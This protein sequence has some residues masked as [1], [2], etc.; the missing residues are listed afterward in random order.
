M[1]AIFSG[2]GL[3][4]QRGS[5]SVLGSAGVLGDPAFGRAADKIMVNAATGNLLVDRKD[6]FLVGRGPDA[7]YSQTYNSQG[8]PN[9]SWAQSIYHTL[10]NL[11]GT[12]NTAG[13]TITRGDGDG[14]GAVYTYDAAKGAYVTTEG[15]GSHDEIRNTGGTWTWTDGNS[16]TTETYLSLSGV[17]GYYFLSSVSDADGNAQT[18]SWN[19]N[20]TLNRITNADGDYVQFTLSNGLPTQITTYTAAGAATLTRTRYV[21][22]SLRRLTSVT[23]DLTPGDHSIGDGKSYTNSYTYDGTSTRITSISQTD[24]SKLDI[25]YVLVGSDYRVA[26]LTQTVAAGSTRTTSFSYDTVNRI[27]SI[28]DANGQVTSLYYDALKQLTKIISPPPFAGAAASVVQFGYN[29]SGDLVSVTDSNNAAT[30]YAYDAAG[31]LISETDPLGN[32]TT[33]TYGAKNELLIETR[34][35]S[36]SASAD[37]AQTTRYAYDAENHLRYVVGPEGSVVEYRYDRY[38]QRIAEIE[39]PKALY[40]LIG[41]PSTTAISEATLDNWVSGLSDKSSVKRTNTYYDA[42]GNVTSVVTYSS[43]TKYGEGSD[44]PQIISPGTNTTVSATSDGYHRI[45]KTSGSAGDWDADAHSTTKVEGDFVLRLRP[46]QNNKYIVAGL[47]T[48]PAANASYT[49]P[50]YGLYFVADGSVYYMESGSYVYLNTTYA[51]GDV[52]WIQRVGTTISYYKGATLGAAQAAGALRTRTSATEALYFD[53]SF[54]QTGAVLDVTFNPGEI[55]TGV[56]TAVKLE[57]DGLY[58]IVKTGGAALGWDADAR[59]NIKADGDF[60]LRLRPAQ[61]NAHM[62]GGVAY[63]P[64]ANAD[65][66]NPN[67]G[68]YFNADS[69][70]YYMESGSYV[71]LGVTHSAG[72]NFWLVRSGTTVSYY[73]G[74]SLEAAMAAGPLRTRTGVSGTLYF[75]SSLYSTGARM[76]A[77][78]TPAT[79]IANGVN[80]SVTQSPDGLYRVSKTLGTDNWDADAR[81]STKTDGDFVLRLRPTQT[82]RHF[83]GGVASAPGANASYTNPDYGFFFVPGGVVYYMEAGNYAP[84]GASFAAG[85]NFWLTRVGS[86]I[87]YYKGPTLEAAI[88]AGAIRTRTGVSGTFHF[89]SSLHGAGTVFDVSFTPTEGNAVAATVN[90]VNFAYDQSGQLLSRSKEGQNAETYIYDG[91]GRRIGSTDLNGGSTSIVFNDAATQTVVTLASGLVQTSTYNKAGELVSQTDSGS[92][93]AGGTTAHKYDR[94]G[95][96][97]QTTDASGFNKYFVYDKA[98]RL[99]ADVLHNGALTEYRY[100][101]TNRLVATVRYHNMVSAGTLTTLSDPNSTVEISAIRPAFNAADVCSWSVYDAGGRLVSTIDGG[102]GVQAYA[103]D[104]SDRL[105]RTIRY[106]NLLSAPLI[107]SFKTTPPTATVLPIADSSRDSVT[108]N[109]YDKEGHLIAVLDG[110]GYL[111]RIL[112]DRAGQKI[113]QI[114]YLNPTN[115]AYRASGTLND[116]IATQPTHADDRRT[117]YAYDGQGQL[118]FEVDG[119]NQVVEYGYDGAGRVTSTTRYSGALPATSQYGYDTIKSLIA[120]SGLAASAANR[121]SWVVYDAAGRVA[122]TINADDGVTRYTYNIRGKVT[123]TVEY[124][125]RRST[126][127]LPTLATMASWAAGQDSNGANRVTRHFYTARDELRFSVDAEGFVSRTDYDAAG[128]VTREVRWDNAIAIGDSATIDTVNGL[129]TGTWADTRYGYDF[130]G[131]IT[132]VWNGENNWTHYAYHG[133]RKLASKS[134]VESVQSWTSYTYDGAGRVL[135]ELEA[136]GTA[137]VARTAYAYDGH[138]N[139]TSVTDPNNNVTTRT[140]DRIGQMLSQTDP[141]AKTASYQ[142]NAFGEVVKSTDARGYS[143]YN[144]YDRLGRATVTR[145][146]EDYVSETSYDVF[147]NALSVT[148]RY[149]RANNGASV[150]VLPTYVAHAQDST[151]SFQYDRLGRLLKLTD[152]EGH[153][154][155]YTLDAFGNRISVRNKLGGIVTNSFDRRGRLLSETL[156]ATSVDSNGTTT[157]WSVTNRFQYDARGN[158]TKKFEAYGLAEQRST[159]YV[160]DKA[161]RLIEKRGDTVSVLSQSSHA[162]LSPV[163]PTEQFKYDQRGRVIETVDSL[164]A[165][166]LFYYDK[167]NRKTA[168][169][170]TGGTA[171]TGSLSTFTYDKNGNVLTNRIYGTAVAVPATAGGAAPGAPGGE[172]RE[173]SFTYDKL[174][175]LLTTSVANARTGAWNGTYFATGVGT[176]T[177]TNEYDSSGNV[178]KTTDGAGG[179]TL[180]YY[181]RAGRRIATVDRENY[182]TFLTLDAEGNVTQEERLAVQVSGPTTASN[183]ATLRA[184]VAGNSADRITQFAY[185]RNGRRISETRL[186]VASSTVDGSTGALGSG[187]AHSAIQY[188]YNGLGLVSQKT[189]A[190]GDYVTYTYDSTG[191]LLQESRAPF[192]DHNGATVRPTTFYS[193]DGL[194]N[195]TMSRLGGLTPGAGDRITRY[196]YGPGGRL[197]WTRDATGAQF[198]YYYDAAGNIVRENWTRARA[199][200][201]TTLDGIL[202]NRDLK[203]RVTSQALASWNGSAWVRGD[204]QDSAYNTYGDVAQRGTNGLWQEQFAYDGAGRLYRSNSG[205][206]VWRYFVYDGAGNQTLA[207]E[208]EG[209]NL[210]NLTI[211]QALAVATANGAYYVGGAYIDGINATINVFNKRGQSVQTRQ[212]KRQLNATA[213]AVDLAVSRTYNAFGEVATETDARGFT[214]DFV[215]NT[216]GRLAQKLNPTVS[217][218]TESGAVGSARPT[219]YYYFDAAGRTV[220]Y[221][222]ANGNLMTRS[223]LAGTGHEGSEALVTMEYHADGGRIRSDYDLFGDKRISWDEVNRR[224]DM[225][226]DAMGRMTQLSH[227]NGLIDYFGYDILGQKIA[228]WNN[229]NQTPVYGPPQ[230][231]WVQDG[232]WDP[233][234]GWVDTSHWETQTPIVGYTPEKEVTDYDLQGRITRQVAFGGDT[235]TVGYVWSGSLATAGMGTFGGWTETTTYANGRTA[236]RKTDVFGREVSRTDLGGHTT[237]MTY[238]LAGRLIQRSG[239]D[240]LAFEYLNTGQASRIHTSYYTDAQNWSSKGTTYG[241]DA[242]GNLVS[243]RLVD[244]GHSYS[245]WWDPYYGWQ[246]SDYGWSNVYKNATATYDGMNRLVSWTEAGSGLMPAASIGYQYDLASNIRRS[247]AQYRSLDAN[248]TPSPYVSTQDN[249]YRYDSMNRVV[250]KGMLSGGQI[251]RGNGGVDYLY[252]QA[253]ERIRAT[254]TTTA[255]ATIYDPYAYWDPYYGYGNQ[256]ITVPYDADSREDYTFDAAGAL[257]TVR[258]AQSGYYDNGDGTLTVTPPPATGALRASYTHDLMGRMTHQVDWLGDGTYAAFDRT[259]TYNTKGQVTNETVVQKQGGDTI[260]SYSYND[261][262]SGAAYALGAVTYSSTTTYKNNAYQSVSTTTNSYAWYDGAVQSAISYKPNSSQSTTFSTSFYYDAA[263]QLSSI[264]IYDG[265][266]RSITFVN[267]GA[268]QAIKRDES[269]NKWN[270]GDPHEIWYRFGGKQLGYTGNNG[271]IDTDYATSISNRTLTPGTGAYRFGQSYGSAYADFDLSGE[272]ITSYGQ[273]SV[274]GSYTAR[275]GDT[276]Q[277]IA[278]QLWGDSSLWYKL[279]EANGL[280]GAGALAEGQRIT[281]PAGVLKSQHNASTLRPYDPAET[282]GDVSPTTPQPQAPK[283]AKKNK[284]GIF[285]QILLVVISVAVSLILPA[286]APAVF[287][288]FWGGVGAAM[289]GSVVSQG[290]GLATGIQDKFNWKSVAMAGIGAAVGGGLGQALGKT[291]VAGSKFLTDVVRGAASSAITQGIGVVTGLQ[292]KFDWAG[293]AAAGVGAGV[294]GLVA[295]NLFK[296]DGEFAKTATGYAQ[297]AATGMAG[298]IASAATRSLIEGTSFGDNLLSAL[299]DVIGTTLG[300]MIADPIVAGIERR[301]LEARIDKLSNY[302]QLPENLR[303]SAATLELIRDA[304]ANGATNKRIQEILGNPNVQDMLRIRQREIDAENAPLPDPNQFEIVPLVYYPDANPVQFTLVQDGFDARFDR[305]IAERLA[306]QSG[307]N[308]DE[309]YRQLRGLPSLGPRVLTDEHATLID[310]ADNHAVARGTREWTTLDAISYASGWMGDGI[311]EFKDQWVRG[312]A[313]TINAAADYYDLPR[314]LVAGVAYSE[315]GGDPLWWDTAGAMVS[316]RSRQETISYGNMSIQLRRAGETLGYGRRGAWQNAQIIASLMDPRTSIWIAAAHLSDLRAV[317]FRGVGASQMTTEQIQITASRYNR[318]PQWTLDQMRRDLS[319]GRSITNRWQHLNDLIRR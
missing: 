240:T 43:A 91:L 106:A 218:T 198:D 165:R 4:F 253:G 228:H 279:A 201:S 183:P 212:P 149:N 262:G 59:S 46:A 305:M 69:N 266:P 29:G 34:S 80:T 192:T 172:Y 37:S 67:F 55:A 314:A 145:D 16:R 278:M 177:S 100:D 274:S 226:Y 31:N 124:A 303:G 10:A 179:V 93:V 151:T 102:G 249:W 110:E 196:G 182:L 210:A 257:A 254:K 1:V 260:T 6:E 200:G 281:I 311:F 312:Y 83:V 36:D 11:T 68:F 293:V 84:I 251:V 20:G 148:R 38:G 299:P 61:N 107:S 90:R 252:N 169:V 246:Y 138:G 58:S 3:G 319:Y 32:V 21:W 234:Y 162:A 18:Y 170:R 173:T 285:G 71:S 209:T 86:T 276:L 125:V 13:S 75:D 224:T 140:Y 197:A 248:G 259:V 134:V 176:V 280:G 62:V 7:L 50:E 174:N 235:T 315:V 302:D 316:R 15:G 123:K 227:P 17:P 116:L 147:G 288:G 282:L 273:G 289:V 85:D 187:A 118:R 207:L 263:G 120:S 57:T 94:L 51:A 164:G 153:Y 39:Y 92:Y 73:K 184:S 223:L 232:Y 112:Y 23:V 14:H 158:L 157:A 205:D 307:G 33:R 28:T 163:A 298:A 220:G 199:D 132:D 297:Q 241:Y 115:A 267:D 128:R 136:S 63:S 8:D 178:I 54:Y 76:D 40:Q 202:Y 24:G 216:M 277:S 133:N 35:G 294:S 191:R 265:R 53:S 126:G 313:A 211:D 214:T 144:Y 101:S 306:R 52:F 82:D 190:N 66:T 142:Y 131:E 286:V 150:G 308:A 127:S 114:S 287:G 70:V 95:R 45:T 310:L 304:I 217:Y 9:N 47:A 270:L 208:S 255:W 296:V 258:I 261:F 292:K 180:F 203:G 300:N 269:D 139:V 121:R 275:S 225:A 5:S 122:F 103:Y 78:F 244:E 89:D 99:I 109:F 291:G 160:Y 233:Y 137:E 108:R 74:A 60:V 27:T 129:A 283:A 168:E 186:S 236:I 250:T 247:N 105:V 193:Y 175:R 242:S 30:T 181:D 143:T 230:Q 81:S 72:D 96:L 229:V 245:E 171:G 113:E 154:E 2:N 290:V 88:A 189:Y 104:K 130:G 22:D 79:A 213:A 12:I 159:T 97:R 98:G 206:G 301:R 215:Y 268:G 87:S 243:E 167:L 195:L 318:G 166:I 237:N 156:P 194:N 221:R 239:S 222:D 317:D 188:S 295:R 271:T 65:Y 25:T 256:Y 44:S 135:E 119:L 26:T 284:C 146:A 49:N 204:S 41:L 117:R 152:A 77:A 231:V 264:S 161:D 185:D 64:T 219:E 111:S 238:D 141:L 42:R 309:I 19:S 56:N 48:A 272:A 155:Q